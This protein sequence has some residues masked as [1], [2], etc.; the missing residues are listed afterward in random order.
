MSSLLI[1]LRKPASAIL[2]T[3]NPP[4]FI[5]K[6]STKGFSIAGGLQLD[7]SILIINGFPLKWALKEKDL[8]ESNL[9]ESLAVFEVVR[10]KPELVLFGFGKKPLPL[11]PKVNQ[12]LNSL[13]IQ[14]DTMN[15]RN[16]AST[17]NVLIEEGRLVSACLLPFAN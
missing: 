8:N 5:E 3:E 6:L 17:Y 14:T 10:P 4:L 15:T 11:P 2:A 12:Y 1:C 13:G 9:L 7:S 16:A